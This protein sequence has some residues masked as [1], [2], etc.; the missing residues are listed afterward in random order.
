MGYH[1]PPA[2]RADLHAPRPELRGSWGGGSNP[3]PKQSTRNAGATDL[4]TETLRGERTQEE[5]TGHSAE[6]SDIHVSLLPGFSIASPRTCLWN[7][8]KTSHWLDQQGEASSLHTR[9]GMPSYQIVVKY[10]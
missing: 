3:P 8:M 4:E 5:I 1:H 6:Q 2:C 7:K 9:D 10:K